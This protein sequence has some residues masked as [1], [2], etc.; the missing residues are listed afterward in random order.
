VPA[1]IW[2]HE[3]WRF[4]TVIGARRGELGGWQARTTFVLALSASAVGMG[5]LWRFS[6]LAGSQGGGAFV[7]T[8]LLCLFL[9]AVPLLVAEVVIGSHGRGAPVAAI[10]WT[11]DRS[12]LS[13][14]WVGLGW[15]ACLTALLMLSYYLVVAGWGMAYGAAMYGQEFSAMTMPMVSEQFAALLAEPPRQVMWQ[16]LFL[17]IV[18]G[19]VALGVERGLG[20]LVWLVVPSLF[21]LL[22]VL[23]F[24]ALEYGD[25]KA[26]RDFLFSVK[27]VDFTP[28][29]VLLAMGHAF[30]TLGVGVGV[31]I[32][33][34]AY[35]P[36]DIPIGRSV[37]A[38]A[39]FDTLIALLAGM[40]V[41]PVLFAG[42]VAPV[43]GP[44]LYFISLPYA[45]GNLP[46]GE[47]FGSLFF[48]LLVLAALG[49]AVALVE[50]LVGAAMQAL[51][52][53]RSIAV[54]MLLGVLW[55]LSLQVARSVAWGEPIGWFDSDNLLDFL[56]RLTAGVLLPLVS[57]L[58]AVYVGWFLRR[59]V[60]REKFAR[61][62]DLS[63]SVW[64]NLLRYVA[65]LAL[66]GLLLA[67][68]FEN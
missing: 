53:H 41:F 20:V 68:W 42:N 49:T 14:A 18:L 58:T 43:G 5:N 65:P 61:E 27:L 21:V 26:G 13:R 17:V 9:L 66:G 37:M 6:Y 23:V 25:L 10:R 35:A 34:G 29:S 3:K 28:R 4:F 60:L 32:S 50:V 55:L 62:S 48:L 33:Y 63:F 8:Y 22:I 2:P 40:A 30:F 15:L 46:Q 11:S 47:V 56:D 19:L 31:G 12:L 67:A 59:D 64:L 44:A 54:L 51:R 45:F 36:R 7:I 57:L 24:F 1:A 16:S 52:I 39:V 38:V